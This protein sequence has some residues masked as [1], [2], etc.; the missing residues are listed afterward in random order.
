MPR[1]DFLG[2]APEGIFALFVFFPFPFST[3]IQCRRGGII[4]L[5]VTAPKCD[6][7]NN[8]NSFSTYGI[9]HLL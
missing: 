2:G 6:I 3:Y 8:N 1:P 5:C 4:D 7:N 9:V